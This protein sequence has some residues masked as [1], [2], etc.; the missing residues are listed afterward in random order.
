MKHQQAAAFTPTGYTVTGRTEK[1]R[2][3]ALRAFTLVELLVVIA[4]IGILV[5][6][7]LPAIQAAREA[8]RRASCLNKI[9]QVV[10]ACQNFEGTNGHFPASSDDNFFSYLARIL[11]YHEQENFHDLIDFGPCGKFDSKGKPILCTWFDSVNEEAAST[12]MPL[13][14]C[15]SITEGQRTAAN[16]QGTTIVDEDSPL[17]GH[18]VAVM[19]AKTDCP[20]A[21]GDLYTVEAKCNSS[22][23]IATNG[24]MYPQSKTGFQQIADGSSNTFLIAESA[25]MDDG[26]Q[27]VWIVG[28]TSTTLEKARKDNKE[29]WSYGGRNILHPMKFWGVRN[30]KSFGSEH[31]GGAHFGM[32]DGSGRFISESIDLDLYKALA[33]RDA[34]EIIELP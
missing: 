32:A 34:G 31:P 26:Q 18:Y 33:S 13:F 19:G 4:I 5:A 25:W 7:L 15:P 3:G 20:S 9:R 29:I 11:P 28:S 10:L 8:A 2:R 27:R 24:I 17:R 22:G 1:N 14:K 12:P 16:S 30:D 21:V 6:L 23:G